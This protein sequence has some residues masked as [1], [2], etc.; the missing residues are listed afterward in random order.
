VY[1]F[2]DEHCLMVF[3]RSKKTQPEEISGIYFVNFSNPPEL[4]NVEMPISEKSGL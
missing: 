4:V 2:D 3:H 1:K